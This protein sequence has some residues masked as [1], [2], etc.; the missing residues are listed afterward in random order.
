MFLVLCPSASGIILKIV[1]AFM[2]D[3]LGELREQETVHLRYFYSCDCV[4]H[5]IELLCSLDVSTVITV[6]TDKRVI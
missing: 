4:M 3:F 1:G 5:E 2:S 6:T